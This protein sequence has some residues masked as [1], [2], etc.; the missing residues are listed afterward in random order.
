LLSALAIVKDLF[1]QSNGEKDEQGYDEQEKSIPEGV[2]NHH[3]T[4]ISKGKWH[5]PNKVQMSPE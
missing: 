1:A 3:K 4:D 5:V 2:Q